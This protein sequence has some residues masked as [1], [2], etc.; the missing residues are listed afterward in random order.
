MQTLPVSVIVSNMALKRFPRKNGRAVKQLRKWFERLMVPVSSGY[1]PKS[2]LIVADSIGR[3]HELQVSTTDSPMPP[4]DMLV[5]PADV[6]NNRNL[7][8]GVEAFKAVVEKLGY[9]YEN[10]VD[11]GTK[12][13]KRAQDDFELT[14][15][16]HTEFRRVPNP[17]TAAL[18]RYKK[19]IQSTCWAFLNK[20]TVLCHD[21]M[22]EIGDLVSYAQ[23]WVCNYLGLYEID[24][25]AEDNV[26][27]L[28]NYLQQRFSQFRSLLKRKSK[29]VLVTANDY[30]IATT[31]QPAAIVTENNGHLDDTR[32]RMSCKVL[33]YFTTHPYYNSPEP[34]SPPS[35]P[36]KKPKLQ[37]LLGELGHDAMVFKLQEA[38]TNI[39]IH[40]DARKVAKTKL[41]QHGKKCKTCLTAASNGQVDQQLPGHEPWSR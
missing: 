16:R 7:A 20:N 4:P 18:E 38:T 41:A 17:S 10:P 11:R 33:S 37:D 12:P 13:Q 23:V 6:L 35:P 28:T 3:P 29:N 14:A 39:Y 22:L 15:L 34:V 1:P 25:K 32:N 40:P 27:L 36:K 26:K 19:T 8:K 21:H 24:D 2:D 5:V 9:R 30:A 31:G